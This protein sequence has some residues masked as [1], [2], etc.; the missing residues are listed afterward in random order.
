MVRS[1]GSTSAGSSGSGRGARGRTRVP[2]ATAKAGTGATLTDADVVLGYLD[3]E[4]F[5]GG[6]MRLDAGAAGT[7][8]EQHVAEPAG[9]DPIR[10]AWGVHE[11]ANEDVARAFRIHASERG[12][13]YRKS[14]MVAFGG[15]GPVH[16][17]AIARKL[18]I[19]RVVFPI[20]AGVMSALGLLV[21][22]LGFEVSRSRRVFVADLDAGGFERI[23]APLIEEASGFLH[24]AGISNPLISTRLDMRYQ[25][26]GYEIEVTLPDGGA[27]G[28]QAG[29]F[30]R[31]E[32]LFRAKYAEIF[33]ETFLDEPLEIVSWKVEAA[34]SEAALAYRG[35]AGGT[36]RRAKHAREVWFGDRF[37][38]SLVLD[39]YGL[40]AGTTIEG[41]AVI[42]E[43]ESTCVLGPGDRATV[44]ERLNLVAE[45]AND[46]SD[47]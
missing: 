13:D 2:P 26:Q 38:E 35:I 18:Q 10:A 30:A 16:A 21:S 23:I 46:G 12:F 15:S 27:G 37:L 11:I 42:E 20:G 40:A 4:F 45:L 29:S 34:G 1:H 43:R 17:L 41:P 28:G 25:G 31:L 36:H 9:L 33:A 44:D 3:P 8:I 39:R 7:A 14:S 24:R 22:P 47:S 5:L 19:P 6:E 32:A